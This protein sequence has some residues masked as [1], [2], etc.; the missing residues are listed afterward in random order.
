M[1]SYGQS[2]AAELLKWQAALMR[3][4]VFDPKRGIDPADISDLNRRFAIKRQQLEA[5]LLAGIER[6]NQVRNGVLHQRQQMQSVVLTAA[7][8]VAQAKADLKALG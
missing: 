4:F 3:G 7:K 6:L 8:Q 1:S 2:Y 5:G